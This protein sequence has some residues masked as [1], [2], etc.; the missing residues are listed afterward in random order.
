[1]PDLL[2]SNLDRLPPIIDVDF[3]LRRRRYNILPAITQVGRRLNQGMFASIAAWCR[4]LSPRPMPP[5]SP[6]VYSDRP[7]VAL[8]GHPYVI[9]D[10][11]VSMQVAAKLNNFGINVVTPDMVEDYDVHLAA[12]TLPKK[13]FWSNS[14]LLAG[15]ALALIQA[16]RPVDGLIML[17]TFAC[18]PD[19]LIGELIIQYAQAYNIPSMLL[20]LDEH[21]AE[22]GLITRLEAFTDMLQRRWQVCL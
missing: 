2:R 20:T 5:A 22:A 19:A 1:M 12:K 21:T 14:Q 15:A 8:I 9:Y 6:P 4:S 16:P 11:Q 10:D 7:R 17:T 18:G 13:I 3:D